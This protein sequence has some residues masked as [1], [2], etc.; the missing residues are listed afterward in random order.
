M[1]PAASANL[2]ESA[3][4]GA[5]GC[6]EERQDEAQRISQSGGNGNGRLE[7]GGTCYSTI[8]ADHPV[9]LNFP[10][11]DYLKGLVIRKS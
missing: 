2:S 3:A 11:G 8:S 9:A 6:D 10:E 4:A 5:R 1:H 7:R